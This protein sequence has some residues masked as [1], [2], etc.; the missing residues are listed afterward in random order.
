MNQAQC[1][2]CKQEIHPEATRCPHCRASQ[3]KFMP[4]PQSPKGIAFMMLVIILPMMVI[5]GVIIGVTEYYKTSKKNEDEV[6][7][8]AFKSM[9]ITKSEILLHD[10]GTS[11]CFSI[12]GEIH[13]PT[14]TEWVNISV[15]IEVFDDD[16]KL[17]DTAS[18]RNY[19]LRI[20]PQSKK[21][22]NFANLMK[23]KPEDYVSHK[24]VITNADPAK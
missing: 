21:A 19:D 18:D 12:F 14:K 3:S 2:Y 5:M 11:K 22:F 15:Y 9:T 20:P 13:N 6:S 8:Q 23:R 7:N 17:V 24:I 10:C 16:G 4:D 1:R